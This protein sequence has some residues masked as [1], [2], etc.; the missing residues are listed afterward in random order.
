MVYISAAGRIVSKHYS[1]SFVAFRGHQVPWY[2]ISKLFEESLTINA[3]LLDVTRTWEIIT[4]IKKQRYMA[5]YL[6]CNGAVLSL[7][8]LD[9]FSG[10]MIS[11]TQGRYYWVMDW[12]SKIHINSHTKIVQGEQNQGFVMAVPNP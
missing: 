4:K 12:S 5:D 6:W 7:N 1:W 10:Y 11:W 2:T 3:N 8:I 9:I